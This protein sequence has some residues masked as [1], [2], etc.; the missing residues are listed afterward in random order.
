MSLP[1]QK[2]SLNTKAKYQIKKLASPTLFHCP[3]NSTMALLETHFL[4]QIVS[5]QVQ[6]V[7]SLF[8]LFYILLNLTDGSRGEFVGKLMG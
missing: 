8:L 7:V 2:M 5:K 1:C 6:V 3:K 4:S